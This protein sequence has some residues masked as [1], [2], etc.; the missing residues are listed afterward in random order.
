MPQWLQPA[1]TNWCS[2]STRRRHVVRT[3]WS[4]CAL[5]AS[6]LTPGKQKEKKSRESWLPIAPGRTFKPLRRRGGSRLAGRRPVSLSVAPFPYEDCNPGVHRKVRWAAI[7]PPSWY[8]AVVVAVT[9]VLRH[10]GSCL[11]YL[12]FRLR[13]ASDPLSWRPRFR[14]LLNTI[15]SIPF[16]T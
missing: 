10:D 8:K 12:I 15:P 14:L 9:V 6:T 16:I 2:V 13:P 11:S 4:N 3:A 1:P 5:V 7:D